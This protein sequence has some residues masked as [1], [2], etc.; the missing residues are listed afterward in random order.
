MTCAM[1]CLREPPPRDEQPMMAARALATLRAHFVR[2]TRRLR[3]SL[4]AGRRLTVPAGRASRNS[5]TV[6]PPVR[7]EHTARFS[8][9]SAA[10]AF[11]ISTGERRRRRGS[12]LRRRTIWRDA[13]KSMED[14]TA[15]LSS[16]Q[17]HGLRAMA[18]ETLFCLA[19]TQR[20]ASFRHPSTTTCNLTRTS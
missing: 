15:G 3:R 17:P 2:P 5:A 13:V 1:F 7:P 9:R 18:S 11:A 12:F 10:G 20:P 19:A 14:R 16:S 4:S 6:V 8:S